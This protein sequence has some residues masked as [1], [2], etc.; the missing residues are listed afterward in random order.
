MLNFDFDYSNL[1]KIPELAFLEFEKRVRVSI[2]KTAS[3][4]HPQP[5]RITRHIQDEP[6]RLYVSAIISFLRVYEI[7][8]LDVIDISEASVSEFK[9]HFD[10]F[11]N[12]VH[13]YRMQCSLKLEREGYGLQ[14]TPIQLSSDFRGT[15]G[16]Q[17]ELVRKIVR[18]EIKDVNKRDAI[19]AKIAALQS[20]IDRE[21][22][23]IDQFFNRMIDFSLVIKECGENIIPLLEKVDNIL[24]MP[25]RRPQDLVRIATT[26]Y[27]RMVTKFRKPAKKVEPEEKVTLL[28]RV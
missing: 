18:Q 8:D 28:Q 2:S 14:G 3:F 1:P 22:T 10:V 21:H 9:A 5:S 17:L 26:E 15:I 23:S 20:E 16:R 7:K 11:R 24:N 19:L 6:Q 25:I 12:R 13:A 4:D 27:T